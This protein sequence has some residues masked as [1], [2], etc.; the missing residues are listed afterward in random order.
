[1]NKLKKITIFVLAGLIISP[2][3]LAMSYPEMGGIEINSE[4]TAAQYVVYFFNFA[5]AIGAFFAV[6]IL[7]MAGME[8]VMAKGDPGK[9]SS[10]KDK[11]KNAALGLV[12]L[13]ASYMILNT[14]NSQLT[15]V[16]IDTLPRQEGGEVEVNDGNGVYLYDSENFVSQADPLVLTETKTGFAKDD[17]NFK[18]RSIK[19]LNPEDYK[20]GAIFFDDSNLMGNC[21][22]A[23]SDIPNIDNASGKENN[24]AIANLLSAI[25]FKTESKAVSVKL[26]NSIDCQLKTDNYCREGDDDTPCQKESNKVCTINSGDGFENIA[27]IC[28]EFDM[29]TGVLSIEVSG[30]TGILLKSADK[31]S[32]GKCQFFESSNTT[33]INTVKYSYVYRND[34][35]RIDYKLSANTN[36][37]LPSVVL[38]NGKL[39]TTSVVK[40]K[41][42]SFM[43]FPLVR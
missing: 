32:K 40:L 16:S 24:P 34:Y 29:N 18:T 14:I 42:I 25:V 36:L 3:A 27:T 37:T 15:N 7:V 6:V 13:L 39:S 12:I 2:L 22:Y 26:Y 41:P 17:N 5:I 23:L 31:S 4:T 9:L 11:I 33:C 38:P 28:P 8:Y 1:M 20:F 19:F 30:N 43:L 21:S 35:A 10:A